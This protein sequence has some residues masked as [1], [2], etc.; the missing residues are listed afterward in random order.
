MLPLCFPGKFSIWS[1]LKA[2]DARPLVAL[3][4]WRCSPRCAAPRRGI[5]S[6]WSILARNA[7]GSHQSSFGKSR[8]PV[9]VKMIQSASFA[10]HPFFDQIAQAS[11]IISGSEFWVLKK[12]CSS[13]HTP[14]TQIGK[15]LQDSAGAF[16][17]VRRFCHDFARFGFTFLTNCGNFEIFTAIR[18]A[19][20][21]LSNLAADRR[22]GSS[23]K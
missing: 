3:A 8:Q 6:G 22:P 7:I 9:S 14:E 4:A 21:L 2:H 15:A 18:R 13:C 5:V 11:G 17:R 23:S 1:D 19:S 16:I 20:S 12:L 10:N